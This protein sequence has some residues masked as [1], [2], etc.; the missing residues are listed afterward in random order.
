MTPPDARS[1]RLPTKSRF[2]GLTSRIQTN[3]IEEKPRHGLSPGQNYT[4]E[5]ISKIEATE[6]LPPGYLDL[7]PILFKDDYEF[8]NKFHEK[9]FD[10]DQR[11]TKE[12]RRQQYNN[13]NHAR[14][15]DVI[16]YKIDYLKRRA[17]EILER[18]FSSNSLPM[19]PD[20]ILKWAQFLKVD[21]E[22]F[23]KMQQ[24]FLEEQ[25]LFGAK[26][27]AALN[28]MIYKDGNDPSASSKSPSRDHSKSS[29]PSKNT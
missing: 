2:T 9:L 18:W 25:T 14:V 8:L 13:R 3:I 1:R 28:K 29:T 5:R 4:K 11:R 17:T 15:R 23:D 6:Y 24:I 21:P 26:N 22:T 19:G 12:V 10:D 27:S 16:I 7:D 20:E